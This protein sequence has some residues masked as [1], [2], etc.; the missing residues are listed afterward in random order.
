MLKEFRTFRKMNRFD[1]GVVVKIM[2]WRLGKLYQVC[3]VKTKAINPIDM[4][5]PS[6]F[7]SVFHNFV[8]QRD[9]RQYSVC[10][11]FDRYFFVLFAIAL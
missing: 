6:P 8:R 7:G 2:S 1:L 11:E 9:S 3:L 10:L 5:S 4:I